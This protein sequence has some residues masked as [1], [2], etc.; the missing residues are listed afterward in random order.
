[1]AYDLPTIALACLVVFI[2]GLAKGGFAGLGALATPLFALG[3][4]PVTAAAILLPILIVQDAV[5]V[6]SFRKS[7]SRWAVGWMLPGA[8]VGVICGYA[9]AASL[10]MAA[11][12]GALGVITLGFGLYRLWLERGGRIAAAA[13]SPGWVGSLFGVVTGF[14]SQIAH[15]GGPPMQMWLTPQKMPHLMFIGTSSILFATINW[16]KVPAYAALGEFTRENLTASALL[17]PL[18]IASTLL[19]VWLVRRINPERFYTFVYLLM[20]LLGTKLIWDGVT[21]G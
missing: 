7:W 10:S 9:F 3:V 16:M 4:A 18:A 19:G 11:V 2:V 21:G 14:T 5:S 12:T 1:M 20:V 13:K 15:A 6:W 8:L 17:M